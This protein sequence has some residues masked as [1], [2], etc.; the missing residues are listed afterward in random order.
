MRLGYERLRVV[1]FEI[2]GRQPG[3]KLW[4]AESRWP[5]AIHCPGVDA[6]CLSIPSADA[7]PRNRNKIMRLCSV[8]WGA[9]SA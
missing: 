1:D 6:H 9:C 2:D 8:F 3:E 7:P 5:A 4:A